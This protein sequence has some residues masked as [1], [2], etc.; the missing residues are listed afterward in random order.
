MRSEWIAAQI[1]AIMCQAT[2]AFLIGDWKIASG[3]F[4]AMWGYGT[5]ITAK[6]WRKGPP[7]IVKD[8]LGNPHVE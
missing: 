6:R 2:G 1:F 3:V 4:L 5:M 7:S 8:W